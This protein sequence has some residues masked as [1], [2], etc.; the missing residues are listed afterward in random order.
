MK[1]LLW[2]LIYRVILAG[3]GLWIQQN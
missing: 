1:V 2:I 3:A